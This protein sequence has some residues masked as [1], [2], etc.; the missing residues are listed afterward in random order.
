MPNMPNKD[1]KEYGCVCV[2]VVL[3]SY[4]LHTVKFIFIFNITVSYGPN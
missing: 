1:Y 4:N 3:N 2:F